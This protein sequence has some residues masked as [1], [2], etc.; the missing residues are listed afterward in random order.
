MALSGIININK[1]AGITSFAAVDKVKKLTREKH[2]GHA[3]TLDPDAT[4]VLPIAFGQATRLI[5]YLSDSSKVYRTIIEL[6]VA[7]DTYDGSGEILSR[8]DPMGIE[9]S[10]VNAA[11]ATFEGV[12]QQVPPMFSALRHNG[13][14]LYNM[15]RA[16]IEIERPPREV[17][18][19]RIGLVEFQNPFVIVD[20]ECGKGTYIRS[21]ASDLGEKLGCGAYMK[22]LIRSRV[23]PFEIAD[24]VSIETLAEACSYGFWER[25]IY[26]PDTVLFQLPSAV[27]DWDKEDAVRKGQKITLDTVTPPADLES[28]RVYSPD[29]R[30]IGIVRYDAALSVWRPEKVFN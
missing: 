15:A 12:I 19:Y 26:A 14:R 7:T 16:G 4:G 6:G 5:E 20:I 17:H 25:Y 28:L 22:E 1:P 8:K 23:G 3:G 2:V 9:T 11:L 13:E 24:A 30:F 21:I 10:M 29:G 27:I 18:I